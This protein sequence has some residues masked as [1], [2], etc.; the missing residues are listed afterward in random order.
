[1]KSHT[2]P[3]SSARNALT[4]A[5]NPLAVAGTTTSFSAL[6][7]TDS[8]QG[9]DDR[10]HARKA[11]VSPTLE[12]KMGVLFRLCPAGRL[13]AA[14]WAEVVVAPTGMLIRG[15][16]TS[17]GVRPGAASGEAA[18]LVDTKPLA[19]GLSGPPGCCGW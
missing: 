3:P 7:Y 19:V 5:L 15:S 12:I 6:S 4:A 9:H 16:D 2:I 18:S 8:W 1:M 14:A 11:L 17:L 10:S 13:V